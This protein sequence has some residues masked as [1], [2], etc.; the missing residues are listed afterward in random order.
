MAEEKP[1]AGTSPIMLMM[2]MLLMMLILIDPRIR[3][4]MGSVLDPVLTPVLGFN[5][6]FP[7]ITVFLAGLM[8]ITLSTILRHFTTNWME[9]ARIQKV[10]SSFNK[11]MRDAR[12]KNDADK[13]KK[14]QEKQ[15][16]IMKMS[17][18][19]SSSQ[20]K[21]MPITMI[22]VIPIFV[23]LSLFI[24]QLPVSTISVPW[25]TKV[26]L[27]KGDVCFFPNWIVLYSLLSIP[28]SQVL[29]RLLKLYKF[30]ERIAALPEE[31]E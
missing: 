13:L 20:M 11:E 4:A 21:M 6:S 8:S 31:E 17:L 1:S 15:P 24:Y 16:E 18:M 19:L 9:L 23:W 14:L 27:V 25:A 30:R 28:F 10:Q 3:M 2:F 22:F 29:Q 7:L 26:S 5:D 12:L